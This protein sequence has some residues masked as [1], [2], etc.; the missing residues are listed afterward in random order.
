M[1][2]LVVV[3]APQDMYKSIRIPDLT[4]EPGSGAVTL[5]FYQAGDI[6]NIN[7]CVHDTL[8]GL[9]LLE[10]VQTL[11]R[12]LYHAQIGFHTGTVGICFTT[13][14]GDTVE[15]SCFPNTGDPNY[16]AF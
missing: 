10:P 2:K 9:M 11:V 5:P 3:K 6:D 15:N 1:R 8:R 7:G 16:S 12:Y 14:V 4:E 13:G